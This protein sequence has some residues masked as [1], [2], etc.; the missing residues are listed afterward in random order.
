V[1]VGTVRLAQAGDREGL[2]ALMSEAWPRAFRL[3]YGVLGERQA[4]EDVA[5][6]A[7]LTVHRSLRGLRDAESFDTWLASIVVRA[8]VRAA[9]SAKRRRHES[10]DD[11]T[12]LVDASPAI[13]ERLD[14]A[15]AMRRCTPF[16]RAVL[17]LAALGYTSA[18]I[19]SMVGKPAGTVRY[20]LSCARARLRDALGPRDAPEPV[21][22]PRIVLHH[23]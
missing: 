11:F 18:E 15:D 8:A 16:E 19:G 5:Q 13:H 20:Q 9:K 14:L 10:L 6:D 1:N 17:H 7:L 4:A 22:A 23:A 3:A 2:N 12:A 21:T